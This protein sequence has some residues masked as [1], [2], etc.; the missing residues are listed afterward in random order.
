MSLVGKFKSESYGGV[1][2]QNLPKGPP[3][4]A[5]GKIPVK[6]GSREPLPRGKRG[7]RREAKRRKDI[8]GD[9]GKGRFFERFVIAPDPGFDPGFSWGSVLSAL[10]PVE[11]GIRVAKILEGD[12]WIRKAHTKEDLDPDLWS[13]AKNATATRLNHEIRVIGGYLASGTMEED[14]AQELLDLLYELLG[15]KIK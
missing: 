13:K 4:P 10:K 3:K 7:K 8:V 14:Q 9:L 15:E 12:L 6:T 5:Q 2:F 11:V 1:P